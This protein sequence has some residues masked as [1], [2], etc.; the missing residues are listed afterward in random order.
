MTYMYCRVV[1]TII[2]VTIH[3]HTAEPF[4]WFTYPQTPS[5]LVTTNLFYVCMS[6]FILKFAS[7]YFRFKIWVK[8]VVFVFLCL[9]YLTQH[10]VLKV[11]PCCSKWEDFIILYGRVAF[12]CKY[13]SHLFY[14]FFC[15]WALRLFPYLGYFKYCYSEHKRDINLFQI[16][17]FI[18]F[19]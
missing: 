18:F 16:S 10:N 2:L 5:P 8:F 6:L 9:T 15:W 1:T 12:H 11:H 19:T 13:M 7:V 3:H 17:V 14:S 4:T